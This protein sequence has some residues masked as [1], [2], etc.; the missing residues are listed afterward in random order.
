MRVAAAVMPPGQ[1]TVGAGSGVSKCRS[2]TVK[3]VS[4]SIAYTLFELPVTTVI[5]TKSVT[6]FAVTPDD[7]PLGPRD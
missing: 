6:P 3:P 2:H 1:A 7:S 4:L 5:G